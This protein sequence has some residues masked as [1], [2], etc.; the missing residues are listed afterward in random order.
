MCQ[1]GVVW[2][3]VRRI[4]WSLVR[5]NNG[6]FQSIEKLSASVSSFINL[7][8]PLSNRHVQFQSKSEHSTDKNTSNT[9]NNKTNQSTTKNI[10]TKQC[11]E[12]QLR[13]NLSISKTNIETINWL[14]V[15]HNFIIN[16]NP[17]PLVSRWQNHCQSLLLKTN[18]SDLSQHKQNT[19]D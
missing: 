3:L 4:Y 5:D 1:V 2:H 11:K 14:C 15:L 7:F 10:I 18:D 13:C 16:C 9:R 17:T 8:T 6:S 12:L 19:Y